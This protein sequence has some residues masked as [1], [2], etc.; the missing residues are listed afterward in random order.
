MSSD[1]TQY[2]YHFE[3]P[4]NSIDVRKID[5]NDIA[6]LK[7]IYEEYEQPVKNKIKKYGVRNQYL[8]EHNYK[9]AKRLLR[10]HF[11]EYLL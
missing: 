9:T 7:F 1:Y 5:D 4:I 2:V 10:E 8:T 6:F 3:H 11:L